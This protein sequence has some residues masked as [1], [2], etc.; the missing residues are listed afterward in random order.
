MAL[1][2]TSER[3]EGR[4]DPTAT[5]GW[6][7]IAARA[8]LVLSAL[9]PAALVLI[10]AAFLILGERWWVTAV[11]LYLPRIGFALPLPVLLLALWATGPRRT[12][13]RCLACP[14]LS[15]SS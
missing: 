6:S 9:Y 13:G 4:K 12:S 7:G 8:A 2:V 5:S 10:I 11:A 3:R 1:P 14:F 15:F